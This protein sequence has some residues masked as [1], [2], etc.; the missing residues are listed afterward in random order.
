VAKAPSASWD[1]SI[2]VSAR[3][4]ERGAVGHV[5]VVRVVPQALADPAHA[6]GDDTR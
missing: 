6:V 4:V 1:R 3:P 5:V 2:L